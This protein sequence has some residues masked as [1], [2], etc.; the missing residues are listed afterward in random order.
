[1]AIRHFIQPAIMPFLLLGS[2]PVIAALDS[3]CAP[4]GNFDLSKW[5]LQMPTGSEGSPDTI[6]SSELQGCSG[7]KDSEYFYTNGDD[8]SLVMKVPGGP[9][10]SDCVTTPNSKHCRT[11][12]REDDPSSWSPLSSYNRLFADLVVTE[13]DGSVC[14][15]QIHIDDSISSKPVAELYYSSSGALAMG[16]QTCRTCS[17]QRADIGNVAKGE[18]FT[19]E[20][21]YEN[22]ELSVSINGDAFKTLDTFE[23]DS[24]DSYFKAGNYNQG[25]GPTEVHFFTIRVS[26]T[27]GD[28]V[29]SSSTVESQPS[30]TKEVQLSST[31]ATEPTS[32]EVTQPSST[33]A[34][35]PVSTEVIQPS[36]TLVT[37]PSSTYTPQATPTTPT[38]STP[39]DPESTDSPTCAGAPSIASDSTVNLRLFTESNCCSAIQ[40]MKIGSLNNCHNSSNPFQSFYEAVGSSMFGRNI[41][42]YTYTGKD[43][44]GTE[45]SFKLTNQVQCWSSGATWNSFKIARR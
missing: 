26:H 39:T 43:C 45:S 28:E 16:V 24:P 35:N 36:S 3:S 10:T 9:D 33:E 1:M 15:G 31:E 21:R 40:T 8:G 22:G 41:R 18:R 38:Q 42:V 19:Y 44:S 32:T 23:L 4:G 29:G 25:D 34:T 6:S 13:N 37:L 20:I 27:E 7:Y 17:Q 12:L 5:K 30:S 11:E 2:M 14:I